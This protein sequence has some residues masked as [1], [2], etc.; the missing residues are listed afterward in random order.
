M[1]SPSDINLTI[2][3]NDVS[4]QFNRYFSLIILLFGSIGNL[5]NCLVLSQPSLRSNPCVFLFLMSSIA[6]LI[7]IISGLS[8]RVLAGWDMDF[9]VTNGYLCKFRVYMMFVSRTIAF[10]LIAF[11]AVDRWYSS[12]N[13]SQHRQMSSLQNAQRGSIA[14]LILSS[15]VYCQILYC[16]EAN[17]LN[18]PL[19]CYGKT[20]ICRLI[21]DLTYAFV[22]IIFPILIMSIFGIMTISNIRKTYSVIL[23]Q[24]KILV[25]HE[26]TKIT[27]VMTRAQAIRLAGDAGKFPPQHFFLC[28]TFLPENFTKTWRVLIFC[29]VE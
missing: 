16:Y 2:L 15:L 28:H 27:L 24:R 26:K 11:A 29:W 12:C 21:T 23:F 13:Q 9:T 18:T 4:V 25:R 1:S 8:T 6:N 3:L 5:L 14:I 19:Q 17:L 10:W 22:T 7:S 20:M